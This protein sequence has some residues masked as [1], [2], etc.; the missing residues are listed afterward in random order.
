MGHDY[1]SMGQVAESQAVLDPLCDLTI[2]VIK[3][4]CLG[5][6]SCMDGF[7]VFFSLP[8]VFFRAGFLLGWHPWAHSMR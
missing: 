6:S 4:P 5:S 2:D 7:N 3:I 1:N 8:L